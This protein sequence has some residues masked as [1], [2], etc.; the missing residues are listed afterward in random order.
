[1]LI[2]KL[3]AINRILAGI[4]EASINTLEETD[5]LTQDVI[6]AIN[7]LDDVSQQVQAD[8]WKFNYEENFIF[9]Q[10]LSGE[11]ELPPNIISI[12]V[13]Y[14]STNAIVQ[15]GNKLYDLRNHTYKLN[16]SITADVIFALDF[17]ELPYA[18]Q[19]Y[20]TVRAKRE[21]QEEAL[22]S[23]TITKLQMNNE[24]KALLTL[25]REESR[26]GNYNVFSNPTLSQDLDYRG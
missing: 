12:D 11:V 19:N 22:G 16:Q 23:E 15:R 4:G 24:D 18:A 10:N 9:N 25:Q 26:I 20:I 14:T 7:K 2:S 8:G 21:F 3:E 6:D 17:E 5:Y 1:M 13:K